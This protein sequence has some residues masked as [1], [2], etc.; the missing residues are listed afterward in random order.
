MKS[1]KQEKQLLLD[2][3]RKLTLK[4]ESKQKLKSTKR[5]L[6]FKNCYVVKN[7]FFQHVCIF[8]IHKKYRNVLEFVKHSLLCIL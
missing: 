6:N 8:L 7:W 4:T 2:K 1:V 5:E 3:Q